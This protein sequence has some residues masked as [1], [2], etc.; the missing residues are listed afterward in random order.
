MVKYIRMVI[1]GVLLLLG[2]HSLESVSKFDSQGIYYDHVR[3]SDNVTFY[4]VDGLNLKYSANLSYVG[5]SYELFFDVVNDSGVDVV[6]QDILYSKEDPYIHY[7]LTYQ[8]GSMIQDG[9]LLQMGE[10][11]TIHYKVIYQEPI[12][13]ESYQF[14]SGFSL[15]FEQKI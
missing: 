15:Q 1:V 11:K 9:N 2:I 12:Q 13:E 5:D 3:Y 7:E 10:S 4:G 14:D 8:D 6:I